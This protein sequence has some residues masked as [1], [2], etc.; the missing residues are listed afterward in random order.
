MAL[1]TSRNALSN[2]DSRAGSC[3]E[4]GRPPHIPPQGV[5]YPAYPAVSRLASNL[6]SGES[7]KEC[8]R[9]MKPSN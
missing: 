4:A 9:C 1:A 2:T 7:R 8:L 3:F 6:L 5:Q